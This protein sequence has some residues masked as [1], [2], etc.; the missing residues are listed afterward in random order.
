M[1]RAVVS[2]RH[3]RFETTAVLATAALVAAGGYIHFCLYRHGYRAIPTIGTAF[4]LQAV[5]SGVAATALLVPWHPVRVGAHLLSPA[6]IVKLGT[7]LLSAGTLVGFWLSRRP[8]GIFHFQERGLEP[9]PQ[10]VLALLTEVSALLLAV[11]LLALDRR[12]SHTQPSHV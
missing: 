9:A 3:T 8:G 5:S 6:T 4:L 7:A 1:T 12:R 10:A 2:P 11:A